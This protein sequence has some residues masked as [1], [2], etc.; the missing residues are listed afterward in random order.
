MPIKRVCM[1][2]LSLSAIALLCHLPVPVPSAWAGPTSSAPAGSVA[3]PDPKTPATAGDLPPTLSPELFD[4]EVQQGYRIAQTIPDVLAE[5]RCY[6]GCD[7]SMGHAH[8]LDCFV[9]DHAAG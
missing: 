9:D 8:L 4:G 7:R 2:I 6:C 3:A 5:L 1:P